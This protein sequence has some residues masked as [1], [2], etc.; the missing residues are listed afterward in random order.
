V[1]TLS[2]AGRLTIDLGALAANWQH[3]AALSAPATAGATV[4]ADGYGLDSVRVAKAL[5]AVGCRHFFVAHAQEGARLKPHTRTA[6]V[7]V[8]HGALPGEEQA[9]VDQGLIPVLSDLGQIER[10]ARAAQLA[11]RRLDCH[12]HLDTGMS[13]LGLPLSEVDRLAADPGL[14]EGLTV[15]SWMTHL[16]C[17]DD[18]DDPMTEAQATAMEQMTATLPPAPLCMANS[19]GCYLGPRLT[20]DMTRP[21]IALYGGQPRSIPD[22]HLRPVVEW[23]VPILQIREV[24]AGAP[25]GYGAT[26][27][28]ERPSILAT[29][30]CGYADGMIRQAG[31][32]GG[33]TLSIGGQRVPLAGRVS[34]DLI[35]LDITRI[36]PNPQVGDHVT[37]FG[38]GP[39]DPTINDAAVA[40]ET[41]SYEFLVR[42]G[43]RCE[44]VYLGA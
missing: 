15:K 20:R 3:M 29:I 16:S 42:L 21:G 34:M 33:L 12:I 14:L 19:A 28:A 36:Q 5:M 1:T 17:A 6:M 13:R 22:P 37:I 27:K 32:S 39:D 25:A 30:P 4:K 8:F 38:L 10:W 35:I 43:R 40:A 44:R 9:F 24:P 2:G 41:I 18:P 7:S 23:T 31:S 11:D 26:W